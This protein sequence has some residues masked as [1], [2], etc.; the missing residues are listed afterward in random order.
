MSHHPLSSVTARSNGDPGESADLDRLLGE[1]LAP[2]PL[3]PGFHAALERRIAQE[4]AQELAARQRA[5]ATEHSQ[6]MARLRAGTLSLRR[7]T[8]LTIVAGSFTVG[9]TAVVALPLLAQR[10]GTDVS[11]LAT[12]IAAGGALILATVAV[13]ANTRILR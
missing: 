1:A 6:E 3:P 10:L 11:T 9:A 5:L 4:R 13:L 2:P 7:D 8:L 12:L